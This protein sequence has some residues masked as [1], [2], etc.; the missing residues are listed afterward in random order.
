MAQACRDILFNWGESFAVAS[1]K[2][3]TGQ[4]WFEAFRNYALDLQEEMN[5][6]EM[7]KYHPVSFL[8]LELMA[9]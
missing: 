5:M 6:D 1:T 4:D 2:Q 8:L 9:E 3:S 7:E